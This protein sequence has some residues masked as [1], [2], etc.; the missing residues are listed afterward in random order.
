MLLGLTSTNHAIVTVL[1]TTHNGFFNGNIFSQHGNFFQS[2]GIKIV[3][4]KSQ[5]NRI[6]TNNWAIKIETTPFVY[7]R[8]HEFD[9]QSYKN[10]FPQLLGGKV[11]VQCNLH[12]L[13]LIISHHKT[14]CG[15]NRRQHYFCSSIATC[16]VC[17]C[18]KCFEAYDQKIIN[19]ISLTNEN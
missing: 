5:C 8:V 19:F 7:V 2:G 6:H 12:K 16:K 10:R 17:L 3:L 4:I 9:E 15:C 1:R 11:H 18:K 13:P 14:K